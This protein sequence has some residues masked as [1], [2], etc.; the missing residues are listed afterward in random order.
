MAAVERLRAD[1]PHAVRLQVP[2]KDIGGLL[3]EIAHWLV[4]WR[5]PHLIRMVGN[6]SGQHCII[7]LRFPD[8]DHA[9]ALSQRFSPY[10]VT[11][12]LH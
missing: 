9:Y 4:E 2:L 6:E 5:L 3:K 12:Q 11:Q 8:A 10:V 1:G 7:E